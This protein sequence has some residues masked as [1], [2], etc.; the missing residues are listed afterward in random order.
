MKFSNS[1]TNLTF[2]YLSDNPRGFSHR[3][4]IKVQFQFQYFIIPKDKK[5]LR[6][7]IICVSQHTHVWQ[8]VLVR[9]KRI[10]IICM[11]KML[12]RNLSH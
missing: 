6:N 2:N 12:V 7:I 11:L 8:F 1:Q 10:I 5:H 4:V 9:V 3:R